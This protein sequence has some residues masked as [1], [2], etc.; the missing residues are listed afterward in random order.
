MRK[1]TIEEYVEAFLSE[2]VSAASLGNLISGI[3]FNT[4]KGLIVALDKLRE[5]LEYLDLSHAGTYSCLY[6]PPYYVKGL[7]IILFYLIISGFL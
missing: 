6:F 7:L 2:P 4:G 5:N 3:V 1:R